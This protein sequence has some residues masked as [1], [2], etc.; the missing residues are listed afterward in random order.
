MEI[1]NQEHT[2]TENPKYRKFETTKFAFI[3]KFPNTTSATEQ[4]KSHTYIFIVHSKSLLTVGNISID[5]F[6]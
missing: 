4:K 2:G 3:L 6:A 1:F 5:K